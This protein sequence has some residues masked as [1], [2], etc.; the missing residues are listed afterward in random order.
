MKTKR[1]PKIIKVTILLFSV[2]I[3]LLVIS[4][5]AGVGSVKRA[6]N[7][8]KDMG[9][10]TLSLQTEEKIDKALDYFN[11]LD[12]NIGLNKNVSNKNDLDDAIINYARLAIKKSTVSYNR[13]IADNIS[14]EDIKLSVNE[15][16]QILKKYF[17]ES[18]FEKIEGYSEYKPL[19]EIYKEEQKE[20]VNNNTDSNNVEE[21]EIC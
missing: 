15:A 9:T 19:L 16:Y 18:D 13:R 6:E 10:P 20:D 7:A 5:L 12:K 8:I 11:R 4:I 21:P 3:L 1:I 17:I 2:S 14:D